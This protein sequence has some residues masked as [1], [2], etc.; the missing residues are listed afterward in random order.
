MPRLNQRTRCADEPWVNDSGTTRPRACLLERVVA[1]GAGGAQP[2]LDVARLQQLAVAVGVEGPD[3]GQAVGLQ[4]QSRTE[5]RLLCRL[6]QPRA[7]RV[8][9][10]G[11]AE[12]VL[13][14]VADLVGDDVRLREVAGRAEPSV[15]A[16]AKKPRSRYTRGSGGQ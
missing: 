16:R 1:D 9:A 3:A 7:L 6:R 8:H 5:R 15:A 2:L 11:D 13:D 4:L 12:Q 14:V 10:L